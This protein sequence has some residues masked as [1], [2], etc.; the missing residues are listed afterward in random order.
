MGRVARY[1]G[2]GE[3]KLVKFSPVEKVQKGRKYE[4]GG[5]GGADYQNEDTC[6]Y[7][8]DN[9]EAYS[10]ILITRINTFSSSVRKIKVN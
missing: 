10:F 2:G 6:V 7:C 1:S 3:Y 9:D 4:G 5:S 8:I